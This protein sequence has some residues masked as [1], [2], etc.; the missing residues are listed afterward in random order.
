MQSRSFPWSS[1]VVVGLLVIVGAFLGSRPSR[2]P[3][4]PVGSGDHGAEGPTALSPQGTAAGHAASRPMGTEMAPSARTERRELAVP[5]G[6][7]E[8]TAAAAELVGAVEPHRRHLEYSARSADLPDEQG[9]IDR[10]FLAHEELEDAEE[11]LEL[12]EL[13]QALH[14]ADRAAV[15]IDKLHTALGRR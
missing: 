13:E 6:R 12:A 5:T 4:R 2:A 3:L 8:L 9:A 11:S 7:V 14:E 1:L 10:E 15:M